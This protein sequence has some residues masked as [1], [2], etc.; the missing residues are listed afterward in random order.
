MIAPIAAAVFPVMDLTP[1]NP[2]R[3]LITMRLPYG[4]RDGEPPRKPLIVRYESNTE[5]G[6]HTALKAGMAAQW[7]D[8]WETRGIVSAHVHATLRAEPRLSQA[9]DSS[10]MQSSVVY[11]G[12]FMHRSP[13]DIRKTIV[14]LTDRYDVL[15]AGPGWDRITRQWKAESRR[16]LRKQGH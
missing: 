10:G 16:G 15:L 12:L 7:P 2:Q 1:D 8:D 5:A 4:F 11:S 6:A 13:E 9:P 14:D 3:Q